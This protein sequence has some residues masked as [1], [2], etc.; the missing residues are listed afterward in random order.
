MRHREVSLSFPSKWLELGRKYMWREEFLPLLFKYL[1]LSPGQRVVDVGCGTGFFTRT[2]ARGL[3][4]RGKVTGVDKDGRLLRVAQKLTRE[5][6]LEGM[7]EYRRGKGE[8]LPL[9]NDS[10]D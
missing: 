4:G 10:A 9:P 3:N 5:A 7:I 2:V 6:S 1:E 8:D